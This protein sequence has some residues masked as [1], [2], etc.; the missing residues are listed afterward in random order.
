MLRIQ[1]WNVGVSFLKKCARDSKSRA[2]GGVWVV[3]LDRDDR[4][5][6]KL[7]ALIPGPVPNKS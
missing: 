4:E 7:W 3:L 2:R 6:T 1:R 5:S